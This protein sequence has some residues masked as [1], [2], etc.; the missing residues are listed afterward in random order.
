MDLR[1]LN[2]N[3]FAYTGINMCLNVKE[4]EKSLLRLKNFYKIPDD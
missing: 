1:N 2:V 4:D 3:T